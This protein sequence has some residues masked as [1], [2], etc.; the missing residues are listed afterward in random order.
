MVRPNLLTIITTMSLVTSRDS[1]LIVSHWFLWYNLSPSFF[2]LHTSDIWMNRIS[3]SLKV[4]LANMSVGSSQFD[5]NLKT[6]SLQWR[7]TSCCFM[8]ILWNKVALRCK[9]YHFWFHVSCLVHGLHGGWC[10]FQGWDVDT[11]VK[12]TQDPNVGPL[13]GLCYPPHS[14]CSFSC[15]HEWALVLCM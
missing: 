11:L 6:R 12:H 10:S 8:I 2:S 14:P 5:L 9:W 1:S 13:G 7:H 4:T 3:L 15:V